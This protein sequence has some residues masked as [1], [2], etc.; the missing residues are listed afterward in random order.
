MRSFVY[1]PV[2]S[3]RLGRSLGVDLVPYKACTYD[4]IYCQLGRT[5]NK[6]VERQQWAPLE[7]LLEQIENHLESRPDW[8]TL[9]GSGEPTLHIQI[10]TLIDKIK[11]ITGIPIA[12]LT[13][14]S[15]LWVPEVR[16]ALCRADLVAPSLDA[17][18]PELFQRVNRPHKSI[19]FD[20]MVQGLMDFRNEYLGT[21]WL[22]VLLVEG[23]SG[24]IVPVEEI[25]RIAQRIDPDRIQVNTVVRPP[26]ED[27]A[28]AVPGKLLECYA[29]AFGDKA[30][31]IADFR[32]EERRNSMGIN[33]EEILQLISRRPCTL[34]DLSD[35]LGIHRAEVMKCMHRLAKTGQVQC[36]QQDRRSYFKALRN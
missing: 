18:N 9:S 5:S 32:G 27:F 19:S 4:C 33:F 35:A 6:T 15:M 23:I 25:A 30:E 2:P 20:L 1:G 3:R 31:V 16:K 29:A 8:I 21:Y 11:D 10:G 22:E 7:N 34:D 12:V 24:L 17:G 14:G 13:N 28:R 26:A 36:Y